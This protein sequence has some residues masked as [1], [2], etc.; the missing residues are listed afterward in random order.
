MDNA[1]TSTPIYQKYQDIQQAP[2]YMVVME[3]AQHN[4]LTEILAHVPPHAPYELI[5]A[6]EVNSWTE[7][8]YCVLQHVNQSK[9][10]LHTIVFGSEAFIWS[11]NSS[12]KKAGCLKAEMTYLLDPEKNTKF[13]YCVHCA[14]QHKTSATE[15]VICPSCQVPLVIRRHFS[16]RLGAYM[17]VCAN[18]HQLME[19]AS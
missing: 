11:I 10:G 4:V 15:Q 12:L 5:L 3:Q 7:L 14:H 18:A 6:D 17:G 1:M 13:V 2:R 8:Q 9:A 19:K 16:E